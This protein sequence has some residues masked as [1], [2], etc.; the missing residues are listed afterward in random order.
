MTTQKLSVSSCISFGWTTFKKRPWFFA[1]TTLLYIVIEFISGFVQGTLPDILGFVVAVVVST[2]LYV[3]LIALYLKAHDDPASAHLKDF[4]NPKPFVN[5]LIM[6]ILLGIIVLLGLVLLIVPG[7]ILALV[8]SLTGYAVVEKGMGPISALKES[9]RLTRGNRWKLFV[10][11]LAFFGLMIL[12]AIPL[13]LGLFIVMPV[14]MLASVHAYRTL[15]TA[16]PAAIASPD[17]V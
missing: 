17:A 8:F 16:T 10:L 2:L 7:I 15:S 6:S 12:G 13:L 9:A 3:G 4:W 11:S 14:A 1:G 5:Y